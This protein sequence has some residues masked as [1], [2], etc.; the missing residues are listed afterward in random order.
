MTKTLYLDCFAGISGD[1]FVGAMLDIGLEL[2]ALEGALRKLP[3]GGYRLEANKVDK[4]GL[5]ATH[6]KVLLQAD[7]TERLA[8]SAHT[9]THE[10]AHEHGRRQERARDGS[11]PRVLPAAGQDR[12]EL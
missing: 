8:D 3:L 12:E 4:R 5:Q 10:H 7:A 9:D 1:M 6:F 11:L 2:T